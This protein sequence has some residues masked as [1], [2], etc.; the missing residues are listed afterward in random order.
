MTAG[1]VSRNEQTIFIGGYGTPQAEGWYFT[2]SWSGTDRNGVSTDRPPR[3]DPLPFSTYY[4]RIDSEW[5]RVEQKHKFVKFS[6]RS[7]PP[8]RALVEEHPYAMNARNHLSVRFSL[9]GAPMQFSTDSA[10]YSVQGVLGDASSAQLVAL[11]RLRDAVAGSDFNLGVTLGESREAFSLITDAATR[12][13]KAYREVRRGNVVKAKLIFADNPYNKHVTF[14]RVQ[15]PPAGVGAANG[16]LALQGAKS[17]LLGHPKDVAQNWLELQYGWLPLLKDVENAAQFLAHHYNVPLQ[18]VVRVSAKTKL[19]GGYSSSSPSN[20]VPAEIRAVEKVRIK[21]ILR[22]KNVAMLAGLTDPLSIAWEL[23]PYSFVAD[24]FIPIG[25]WLQARQLSSALEGT[26]VTSVKR[27]SEIVGLKSTNLG[28]QGDIPA[29]RDRTVGYDRSVSSTL[30]V[31]L[32]S[33]KSFGKAASP[34]HCLNAVALLV[35]N[36]SGTGL[37]R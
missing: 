21:A 22:E 19:G 29:Y 37:R 2:K 20:V 3:G 18:K 33:F 27:Y 12:I 4:S 1:N 6:E 30:Q 5:A 36:A 16:L 32:P 13:Y 9:I 11:G 31:P 34:K 7:Y 26:F 17:K 28:N 25:N 24:W 23:T 10:G 15:K 14:R 35:G 8:K